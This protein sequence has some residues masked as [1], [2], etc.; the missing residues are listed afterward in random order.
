MMIGR[1]HS[2]DTFST[3]DGPGIRTVIFMQGCHLRCKYCHNPDTWELDSPAALKYSSLELMTI[4][5]RGIPYFEASGGGITF[6]GGEPLLQH[7]FIKEI[8]Q[9]CKQDNINTAF[10]SSLYIA[11]QQVSEV[12]PFT[13]LV[14]ADIKEMNPEK[15]RKLT[16]VSNELNLRNLQ[17]IDE[18]AVAIWLRYVIVPAWTDS[19]DDIDR[20]ADFAGQLKHLERIELLPYHSLGSHKWSILGLEYELANVSPPGKSR[21]EELAAILAS[22][23]QK[24]VFIQ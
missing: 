5:R 21:M 16:G 23:S 18:N 9:Q 19:K 4:L 6:S 20:L 17:I 15:S 12:L 22:R 1:V 7:K 11:S 3:L 8:F 10:D 2:I 14:L 24:E 13:D